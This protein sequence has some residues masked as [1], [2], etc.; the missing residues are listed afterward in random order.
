MRIHFTEGAWEDYLYW[1]GQD[2]KT[3]KRINKIIKD[4]QRHPFEGIA[5]PEP[6]KYDYQGAWSRRIDAENRLIYMVEADQLYIL[7]LRDH[8]K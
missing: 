3:L 4:M 5:K 8:Y 2:K 6:L 7:S 1:Q